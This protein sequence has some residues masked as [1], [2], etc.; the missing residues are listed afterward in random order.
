[1][2]KVLYQRPAL[3]SSSLARTSRMNV[4]SVDTVPK[5]TFIQDR[6]TNAELGTLN[7]RE[8]G[9]IMG[10]IAQLEENINEREV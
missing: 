10:T 9:Y 8:K 4:A 5:N 6:A 1:M 2:L 7:M 3:T